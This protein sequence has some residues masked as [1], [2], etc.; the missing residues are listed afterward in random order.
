MD[1]GFGNT[2]FAAHQP[3]YQ[4]GRGGGRC[5]NCARETLLVTYLVL[6]PR[7]IRRVIHVAGR[8]T[9]IAPVS[10]D[11]RPHRQGQQHTYKSFRAILLLSITLL[12]PS[13]DPLTD[14]V[15]TIVVYEIRSAGY[16]QIW[17]PM[18]LKLK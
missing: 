16:D 1:Y 5:S 7:R 13:N 18:W 14:T 4:V 9:P 12:I 10:P 2:A 17:L 11:N 6:L 15:L 3:R 8:C